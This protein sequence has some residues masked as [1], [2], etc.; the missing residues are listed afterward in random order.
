MRKGLIIAVLCLSNALLPGCMSQTKPQPTC[1][2]PVTPAVMED[3]TCTPG[4]M[5]VP[6][7]RGPL[8][9]WND[10]VFYEI[11]VRSFYDSDAN[12]IGDLQ[13]LIDKMDYLNDGDPETTDDLGITG[14]WLMPIFES[15][16][17]HGYDVVDYY[18]IESDY[19]DRETLRRFL[20][21]AHAR[22][23]RVIVDL[24]L[25]HTSSQHPWFLDFAS[26][27]NAE[28]RDWYIWSPTNPGYSGPWGERVWHSMN[29]EYYYGIFWSGM[30]DLNYR[31]E[32][33]TMQMQDVARFWLEEIGV[34]GFR[35]DAIKH[36]IEEGRVQENTRA[37]HEWLREFYQFCK[38]INEEAL[39]VGEV[40]DKTSLILPYYDQQ[41]DMCFEFNLAE[42]ILASVRE[43]DPH[44]LEAVQAEVESLYPYHQYATFLTNH[45]QDRVMTQLGGDWE[46]AQL[47]A[48]IYLTSPGVPFIYYGE[49]IGMTGHKPDEYIRTPMQWTSGA[50]AG[51]TTAIPWERVNVGYETKNVETQLADPDSLLNHYKKL[52]NLRSEHAAL[53]IGTRTALQCTTDEVY[54]FLQHSEGE[55]ILVVLNFSG[56]AIHDYQLTLLQS[57]ITAGTYSPRELLNDT[58]AAELTVNA[59][60][61]FS[62][63]Q[64]VSVLEPKEGYIILLQSNSRD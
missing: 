38:G 28:H 52:I 56:R 11:F 13:G 58:K 36:L 5:S 7:Q 27:P 49:E 3:V 60:G 21:E 44:Y 2:P 32:E 37:T 18:E 46:M 8:Y 9:W 53:R 40:W 1:S 35:L 14:I 55:D 25:N 24:V 10:R 43:E 16:S 20:A 12:G 19:G 33:V 31:N 64:P 63:Y 29:G 22:G 47:A 61:G 30:P 26:G 51:F 45:D 4:K 23:I 17:Y 42:A 59:N 41:V 54:A 48:T 39:T 6:T 34:D 15:P 50:N 62:N 57:A